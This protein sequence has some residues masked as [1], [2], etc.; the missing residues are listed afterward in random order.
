MSPEQTEPQ[1]CADAACL[2]PVTRRI[3]WRYRSMDGTQIR[4]FW[5]C[6]AHQSWVIG[7]FGPKDR[8]VRVDA[9]RDGD[10]P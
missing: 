2:Q 9:V 1:H 4:I 7:T 8:T 10:W 6:A 3:H 5:S